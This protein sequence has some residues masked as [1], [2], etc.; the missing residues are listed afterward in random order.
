MKKC[1]LYYVGP[2]FKELTLDREPEAVVVN[3]AELTK[4]LW[5]LFYATTKDRPHPLKGELPWGREGGG[6]Y[7]REGRREV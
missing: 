5:A 6:I 3:T 7:G 2:V 4:T 1:P